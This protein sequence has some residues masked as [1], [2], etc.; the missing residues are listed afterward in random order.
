MFNP[1]LSW[2]YRTE[3]EPEL[4]GRRIY[5]PRGKVLGGSSAING[6][7]YTRGQSHDYDHWCRLGNPGWG[8][9]DVL[10]YFR[11]AEAQI[12]GADYWHGSEGTPS[13]SRIWSIPHWAM[14]SLRHQNRRA[15]LKIWT[16]MAPLRKVSDIIN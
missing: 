3:P 7:I 4:K 1:S 15:C 8:Y 11:L 2:D 6:L 9:E 10:P 16:S 12:R 14:R 13:P 5:W